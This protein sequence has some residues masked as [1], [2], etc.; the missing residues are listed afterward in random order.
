MRVN[1]LHHFDTIE[2]NRNAAGRD[3]NDR[4]CAYDADGDGWT[5]IQRRGTAQH[6]RQENF[7]RSWNEYKHGFG[8]LTDG[9]FWYGND[10][11]HQ[12]TYDDDMQFRILLENWTNER[13]TID[14]NVFRIDA[15]RN[16][17]NLMIDD[18]CGGNRTLDAM[19]YHNGQ[20]FSTFDQQN[21]RT[22]IDGR[23]E[24]CSC[25]VSYASGWWFNK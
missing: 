2:S 3:F 13:L 25:A 22:G 11:I 10:F 8:N 17:Y 20:D 12:L 15:E 21:D 23:R 1:G 5:V 18:F 14:Y 19:A 24:C 9:D 16:N 4:V 7:N 6:L